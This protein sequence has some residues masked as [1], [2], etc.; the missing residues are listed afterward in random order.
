MAE[1]TTTTMPTPADN[2]PLVLK[3][4]TVFNLAQRDGPAPS[5]AIP[6]KSSLL[7]KV[8]VGVDDSESSE[9]AFR[10]AVRLV[11]GNAGEV[12]VVHVAEL[13]THPMED[14]PATAL[15]S[16]VNP[17]EDRLEYVNALEQ[18]EKARRVQAK[19]EKLFD[20][21]SQDRFTYISVEA[22]SAKEALCA[23]AKEIGDIELLIIGAS[24]SSVITRL[25]LGSTAEYTVNNAPCNVLVMKDKRL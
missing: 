20:E 11:D 12:Y 5:P 22:P 1:T 23:K 16:I 3:N 10:K 19:Y 7:T 9:R 13:V 21:V 15:A 14:H 25:V 2:A 24:S 17:L 4:K 8:M 18:R 6:R